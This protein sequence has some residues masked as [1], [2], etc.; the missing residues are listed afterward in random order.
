MAFTLRPCWCAPPAAMFGVGHFHRKERFLSQGRQHFAPI[1]RR[2]RAANLFAGVI[3]GDISKVGHG[4][5]RCLWPNG[6]HY[7]PVA[8]PSPNRWQDCGLRS[9]IRAA[10]HVFNH[11]M[12]P[13]TEIRDS[14]PLRSKRISPLVVSATSSTVVRPDSTLSQ[15]SSRRVRMPSS[16]AAWVMAQVLARS[17]ASWRISFVVTSSS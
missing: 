16:A 13:R 17:W 14:F 6:S 10:T 11:G 5:I 7:N 2:E 15:P 1:R 3:A 9:P 12:R 8:C 4:S